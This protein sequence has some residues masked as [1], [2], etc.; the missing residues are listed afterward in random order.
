MPNN[1]MDGFILVTN[2]AFGMD[3]EH[4]LD[5]LKL[6]I[7]QSEEFLQ[8][9]TQFLRLEANRIGTRE[10]QYDYS[11]G[12]WFGCHLSENNQ[13][14]GSG[15]NN[16]QLTFGIEY[17]RDGL[18][19]DG[20]MQFALLVITHGIQSVAYPTEGNERFNNEIQWQVVIPRGEYEL[21]LIPIHALQVTKLEG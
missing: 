12:V 11:S 2:D 1:G 16:T 9:A 10:V 3:R 7:P 15:K 4:L 17:H 5:M 8:F 14:N 6:V 13:P 19:K 21:Q 18:L 20:L